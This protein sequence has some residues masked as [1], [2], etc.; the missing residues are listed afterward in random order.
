MITQEQKDV[1]NKYAEIKKDIKALEAMAD[2]LNHQV[3]ELMEASGVE[4]IEIGD[5]GKLSMGSRRNWKYTDKVK[6]LDE[7]LKDQ[8]K[9]EEQTGEAEYTE[10]KY[11]IF[12]G[13]KE[14]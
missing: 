4:E 8:K 13:N 7:A 12:K 10:K 3:L 11:V 1:L 9:L 5:M 14:E 2:E 6:A